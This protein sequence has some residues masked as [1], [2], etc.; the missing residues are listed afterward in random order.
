L[1]RIQQTYPG[2]Y[3]SI[4]LSDASHEKIVL[5]TVIHDNRLFP[6]ITPRKS[7]CLILNDFQMND[8]FN[9]PHAVFVE[10]GDKYWNHCCLDGQ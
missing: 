3:E 4:C 1:I 10:V 8:N 7:G 6:I 9:F 5:N 2:P